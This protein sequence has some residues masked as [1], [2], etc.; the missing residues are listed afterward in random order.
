MKT[1]TFF[2]TCTFL[3]INLFRTFIKSRFCT[4][5]SEI[6][7]RFFS[8]KSNYNHFMTKKTVQNEIFSFYLFINTSGSDL[9]LQVD[10]D[11]FS[12]I[13]IIG[14]KFGEILSNCFRSFPFWSFRIYNLVEHLMIGYCQGLDRWSFGKCSIETKIKIIWRNWITLQLSAIDLEFSITAP[15]SHFFNGHDRYLELFL[16]SQTRWPSAILWDDPLKDIIPS[17][18]S[19]TNRSMPLVDEL[20]VHMNTVHLTIKVSLTESFLTVFELAF[21]PVLNFNLYYLNTNR[22]N[23]FKKLKV[24]KRI[25]FYIGY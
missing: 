6:L 5:L 11:D 25:R 21:E 24:A 19:L 10:D 15:F 12:K 4:E 7:M 8:K 13:K 16:H 9:S 17:R 18:D 14:V 23:A 20:D 2:D 22:N 1:I 3:I